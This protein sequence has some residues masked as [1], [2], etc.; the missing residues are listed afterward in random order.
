LVIVRGCLQFDHHNPKHMSDT[1]TGAVPAHQ[2]N[3]PTQTEK[4]L[5]MFMP[6]RDRFVRMMGEE[7]FQREASFALQLMEE[8]ADLRSATR[9]SLL[10]AVM[11]VANIG[12]TLNP[13]LKQAYLITRKTKVRGSDGIERYEKR[14][15]LMPSYVGLM[16]LATDLGV[17]RKFEAQAVYEGDKINLDLGTKQVSHTPYWLN[18][19]ERGKLIGC[20]GIATLDDGS[21]IVEAIG[22]DELKLIR[23]KSD[24]EK[25]KLKAIK[26]GEAVNA[27]VWDEWEG[28]MVR[29]AVLKRLF[30]YVPKTERNLPLMNAIAIDNE[31]FDLETEVDENNPRALVR[32][33]LETWKT[34]RGSDRDE[35]QDLCKSKLEAGEFTATFAEN[36]IAHMTNPRV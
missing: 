4:R 35:I 14:A 20:Y 24:S 25:A 31:D 26:Q 5:D 22:A 27:T 8:N 19:N 21:K 9:T 10:G 13:V 36:I 11:N 30:K 17:V 3:A 29:K 18:G 16:K 28:E 1:T 34:Y 32:K 7:T 6:I 15:A 33:V 12:L 2:D 23:S